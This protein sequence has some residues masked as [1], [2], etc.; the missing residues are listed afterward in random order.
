MPPE[1]DGD[2][3]RAKQQSNQTDRV[4]RRERQAGWGGAGTGEHHCRTRDEA[5]R[6]GGCHADRQACRGAEQHR[7]PERDA[8]VVRLGCRRAARFAEEHHTEHL[9]EARRGQPP[10][11]A[12][13]GTTAAA[14]ETHRGRR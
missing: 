3:A 11:N 12:S 1:C 8:D 5:D 14:T 4:Q 9:H 6:R 7:H 13:T 2:D 10:A